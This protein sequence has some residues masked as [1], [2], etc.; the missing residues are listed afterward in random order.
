[1]SQAQSDA[2]RATLWVALLIV[3]SISPIMTIPASAADSILLSVDVLHVQLSPGHSSNITLTIGNNGSSIEDFNVSI[4]SSG[5]ASS[6]TVL[7]AEDVVEDVLPTFSV[8]TTI[9]VRLA[10]DAQI[11]DSGNVAIYVNQSDGI[12]SSMITVQLSVLPQHG[13]SIDAAAMGD[14]GMVSMAPGSTL[15]LNISITNQGNV[16]DSI[17]LAVEEEPDISQ[18]WADWAAAQLPQPSGNESVLITTPANDS[19]HN[20]S[21]GN[22]S[23][24]VDLDNLTADLGYDFSMVA[25]YPEN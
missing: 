20:I 2:R 25:S 9:V 21:D 1:M 10:T 19:Y 17:L 8:D 7:A 11:S 16:I 15:D 22:L 6:W 5:L 24:S 23:I 13:A 3:A 14:M 12:T 18:W 4:Y